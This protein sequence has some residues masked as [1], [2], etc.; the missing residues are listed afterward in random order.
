MTDKNSVAG[1]VSDAGKSEAAPISQASNLTI[2]QKV[3]LSSQ[4]LIDDRLKLHSGKLE[5]LKTTLKANPEGQFTLDQLPK[6]L[7]ELMPMLQMTVIAYEDHVK[8]EG[9]KA[10]QVKQSEVILDGMAANIDAKTKKKHGDSGPIMIKIEDVI[11]SVKEFMKEMAGKYSVIDRAPLL[12]TPAQ[13]DAGKQSEAPKNPSVAGGTEPAKNPSTV[14]G[15]KSEAPKSN[16][17]PEVIDKQQSL[18][19]S[20]KPTLDIPPATNIPDDVSIRTGVSLNIPVKQS[21]ANSVAPKQPTPSHKSGPGQTV[22]LQRTEP[23]F[24]NVTHFFEWNEDDQGGRTE[25]LP[26][27]D[28]IESLKRKNQ[29][30]AAGNEKVPNN[31][32]SF[33]EVVQKTITEYQ[34]IL[35]TKKY[36]D[37]DDRLRMEKTLV[38]LKRQLKDLDAPVKVSPRP[39]PK[40]KEPKEPAPEVPAAEIIAKKKAQKDQDL[41]KEQIEMEEKMILESQSVAL[42]NNYPAF[43]VEE[44][45]MIMGKPKAKRKEA[46]VTMA[47]QKQRNTRVAHTMENS[48]KELFD[49]SAQ[50]EGKRVQELTY[51]EMVRQ[52]LQEIFLI[53]CKS[54]LSGGGKHLTFEDIKREAKNLNIG[55]FLKF[56]KDFAIDL[57][58]TTVSAVYKRTALYSKEM[59]FDQFKLALVQL[60][61]EINK[62]KLDKIKNEFKDLKQALAN[63]RQLVDEAGEGEDSVPAKAAFENIKERHKRMTA[64]HLRIR[65]ASEDDEALLKY[66]LDELINID[67]PVRYRQRITGYKEAL[68][69][70][71]DMKQRLQQ[72]LSD[73]NNNNSRL[74]QATMANTNEASVQEQL[75]FKPFLYKDQYKGRVQ[76]VIKQHIASNP[77]R[78][79]V[80]NQ[81]QPDPSVDLRSAHSPTSSSRRLPHAYSSALSNNSSS[82]PQ[83][84]RQRLMLHLN[85]HLLLEQQA[86][87]H[88]PLH[89]RVYKNTLPHTTS[90]QKEA[91]YIEEAEEDSETQQTLG[92]ARERGANPRPSNLRQKTPQKFDLA[93]IMKQQEN[94]NYYFRDN[95]RAGG[96][97]LT[98]LIDSELPIQSTKRLS[99]NLAISQKGDVSRSSLQLRASPQPKIIKANQP[100]QQNQSVD[101]STKALKLP[102]VN[103]AYDQ[104][105]PYKS[106]APQQQQQVLLAGAQNKRRLIEQEVLRQKGGSTLLESKQVKTNRGT[107]DRLPE[108]NIKQQKQGA[109]SVER[110]GRKRL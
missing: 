38:D 27:D 64:E 20:K 46:P 100:L 7:R 59:Y 23:F 94:D 56:A 91:L 43:S 4:A 10:Q 54:Q 89:S 62:V 42:K 85:N 102:K 33:R 79:S 32:L 37:R 69:G 49:V 88:G 2:E 30:L 67:D 81:Q 21:P 73:N 28:V 36:K 50:L 90:Q 74:E 5:E 55:E 3:A 78:K 71:M 29:S 16:V 34:G 25:V 70:I 11:A 107:V 19:A 97:L 58:K 57:P 92:M 39:P 101:G 87:Q 95:K 13:S 105:Q 31:S 99:S 65:I 18:T 77:P 96:N 52:N 98:E 17:P 93:S 22:P 61:K 51:D 75:T 12:P 60:M 108:L 80:L 26:K 84:R 76:S 53:Y 72:L 82:M 110:N 63:A 24:R 109:L 86:L 41:T 45:S 9:D 40:K 44:H 8:L 104:S 14:G 35:D 6:I 68:G 83:D 48:Q 103:N 15:P 1:G 47:N 66:C 106:V